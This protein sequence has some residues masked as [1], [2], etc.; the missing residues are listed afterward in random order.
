MTPMFHEL[1]L[2][3]LRMVVYQ[4]GD[5]ADA[6]DEKLCEAVTLNENIR[7]LGFVLRPDDVLRLS[8]SASL[9]GFFSH[10]ESL[11][12]DVKAEPMYPGFPQQVMEMSEAQFRLQNSPIRRLRQM[13]PPFCHERRKPARNHARRKPHRSPRLHGSR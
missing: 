1:L 12:P 4:P 5:P 2:S 13:F 8:V 3:E 11:V 10:L 7:S 9:H 6:T